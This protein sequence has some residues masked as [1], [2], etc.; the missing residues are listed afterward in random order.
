MDPRPLTLVCSASRLVAP[1][2]RIQRDYRAQ[3][4]HL[5]HALETVHSLARFASLPDQAAARRDLT[6]R[7][8]YLRDALLRSP[9]YCRRL[10]RAGLGPSDLRTLDDLHF[11][12]LLDRSTLKDAW[13][14][15]PALGLSGVSDSEMVAVRS[16]GTTG[17]PVEVIRDGYDCLHMWAVLRF[18]LQWLGLALPPTPSIVLLCSLPGGLEYTS[19]VPLLGEGI[20]RRIS[21]VRPDPRER[22]Y[23]ARPQ[24]L[25]SDPAGLHWLA[26]AAPALKPRL[27]LTSA[28]YFAPSQRQ[29]LEGAFAAPII[30][31]YST[32]ETGPIAWECLTAAGRFHVLA[33]DVWVESVEGELVVTRLRP[34]VLP[35]LR[36][37]TGDRGA[38]VFTCCGCGF[39]GWSIEGF[40]GRRACSFLTP[41]GRAVDAWQLAWLFKHYPLRHF[42]LTQHA[43]ND[44]VLEMAGEAGKEALLPP[45]REA[46]SLLGWP[47]ARVRLSRAESFPASLKPEPF[48]RQFGEPFVS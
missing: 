17:E 28:Q 20:L 45:L 36:Y 2:A 31:Y 11:F 15:F 30:N 8:N 22:L 4:R 46:L 6:A 32:T 19:R 3:R 44:F 37:R 43:V 10:K 5:S 42:R 16:S 26:G 47:E 25:F 14:E 24:V 21:L 35:L 27:L 7:L 40:E 48:R 18:W 34:S 9:Y 12:P 1:P 38:V 29:D 41:D 23:R 33:P 39:C 13:E